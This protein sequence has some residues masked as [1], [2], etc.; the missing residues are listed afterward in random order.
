MFQGLHY[1]GGREEINYNVLQLVRLRYHSIP[2]INR[3]NNMLAG[4][5]RFIHR[6]DVSLWATY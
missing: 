2:D 3:C 1:I 5:N 4:K 6:S